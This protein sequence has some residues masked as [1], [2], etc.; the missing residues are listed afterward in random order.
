MVPAKVITGVTTRLFKKIGGK[1]EGEE[2][3]EPKKKSFF[4]IIIASNLHQ[5]ESLKARLL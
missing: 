2:R 5:G 1:R 4:K 3:T